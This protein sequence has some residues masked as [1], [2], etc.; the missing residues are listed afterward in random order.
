[1]V[2]VLTTAPRPPGVRREKVNPQL[3]P[4]RN[5]KTE[6]DSIMKDVNESNFRP[7]YSF[8]TLLYKSIGILQLA[9][10]EA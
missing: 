5:A 7:E 4:P 6:P 8:D 2:A 1:M 3:A 10:E 9:W